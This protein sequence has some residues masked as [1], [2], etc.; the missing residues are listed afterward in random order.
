MHDL[1]NTLM[2]TRLPIRTSGVSYRLATRT[3]LPEMIRLLEAADL[4]TRA[5]EPFIDTFMVAELDGALVAV[6]GIEVHADTAVLRSVAVDEALRGAGVG[7]GLSVR[8]IGLAYMHG[9]NDIYLFTGNA[10]RFW[11]K[12]GFTMISLDDW[13]QPAR[14]SWQFVYVFEHREWAQEF[15]LRTMWMPAQR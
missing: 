8:L 2:T 5:I 7:H 6:G 13:R 1:N 11:E 3:D 4:P 12:Q 10:S 9:V 15:G 14:A